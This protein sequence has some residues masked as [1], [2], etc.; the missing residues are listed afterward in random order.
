MKKHRS[1]NVIH[2]ITC[3][4]GV[5]F[6]CDDGQ[7]ATLHMHQ[8]VM[9]HSLGRKCGELQSYSSKRW[10]TKPII[11]RTHVRV[12]GSSPS[13]QTLL[14]IIPLS[15]KP[16]RAAKLRGRSTQRNLRLALSEFPPVEIDFDPGVDLRRSLHP[17][18][19]VTYSDYLQLM[20]I[21]K[22]WCTFATL[23]RETN[24]TELLVTA[25][26]SHHRSVTSNMYMNWIS[27]R[28]DNVRVSRGE[29]LGVQYT[30]RDHLPG[31][32]SVVFLQ[33][34]RWPLEACTGL[35]AISRGD[36]QVADL[37]RSGESAQR[38]ST[39]NTASVRHRTWVSMSLLDHHK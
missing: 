20:Y 39:L 25:G 5:K 27:K 30:V 22:T 21:L 7:K 1:I 16:K 38:L 34:W 2:V 14:N 11:G 18:T 31:G 6:L 17:C 3:F 37:K 32:V 10:I 35:D 15:S 13:F 23:L 19:P 33:I 12:Y 4:A 26:Y 28:Y 29:M 24:R 36:F 9:P 8:Q